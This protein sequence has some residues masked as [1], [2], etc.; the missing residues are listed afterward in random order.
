MLTRIRGAGLRGNPSTAALGD[1]LD[2][3][4]QTVTRSTCSLA[5]TKTLL[6]P[7]KPRP[8]GFEVGLDSGT[9]DGQIAQ[10]HGHWA[11]MAAG[12]TTV[13]SRPTTN[14]REEIY[15]ALHDYFAE[16]VTAGA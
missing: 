10:L 9:A 2:A 8:W 15:W 4:S 12:D 14:E 6:V 11:K 13:G 5:C 16:A 7:R 3:S 1:Q